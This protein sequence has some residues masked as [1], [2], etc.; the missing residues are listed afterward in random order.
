MKALI[1]AGGYA[2]RLRPLSWT[3]PKLLFPVAGKP[4][5]ERT[6]NTLGRSHVDGVVLA[7]N[8][9][10]DELKS[11]FGSRYGRIRIQ[12][13]REPR[14]LG[15]GGPI[16]LASRLLGSREI[17]LAMNGDILFE[18]DLSTML[19]IHRREKPVATIALHM[20][21]DASRFGLVKVD[22]RM[23]ISSFVEKPEMQEPID[24]L[25]NAGIYLMSPEIFGYIRSGRKVSIE[26]EVFPVLAKQG[27]LLGHEL[28]GY[29][30]DI[31]K[32]NDYLEA[33]FSILKME[34]SNRPIMERGV[35][36]STRAILKPPCFITKKGV[37]EDNAVLGPYTI[38]GE[39]S[40]IEEDTRIERSVLFDNVHVGRSSTIL[41]S[42]LGDGAQI[43]HHA[44]LGEGTVLGEGVTVNAGLRLEGGVRVCA[45]KEVTEDVL[46]PRNICG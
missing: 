44:K 25:I 11:H 8:F 22:D 20:V 15:T 2:T 23:H 9:M 26:K 17:F 39:G 27:K 19:E 16:K 13:S 29:W 7:V 32:I 14:P 45:F 28:K 34:S 18:G 10:A 31:G 40:V 33:N 4:M 1:L 36:V 24:G 43:S 5:L 30:T 12:Y 6:L 42:V 35:K 46:G 21:S 38:V 37:V 3:K 41:G